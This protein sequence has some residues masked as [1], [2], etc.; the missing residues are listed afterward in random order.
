MANGNKIDNKKKYALDNLVENTFF[1]KVIGSNEVKHRNQ[2]D[3]FYGKIGSI[4]CDQVYSESMTSDDA[5]KFRREIYNDTLKEKEQLGIAEEAPYPTNYILVRRILSTIKESF[6]R[7]SLD[8]AEEVVRK[9]GG[10]L[11]FEILNELKGI[12]YENVA[13]KIMD[14]GKLNSEEQDAMA[15]YELCEHAY[16]RALAKEV[17]GN[18]Y[19]VDI[20]A[21]RKQIVDKY[22]TKKK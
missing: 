16:K 11:E 22:K 20:N 5:N 14:G 15:W 13:K 2:E 7:L 9:V 21:G 8:E 1:Q 17:I 12:T 10:E 4:A 3:F 18:N 19:F 6:A